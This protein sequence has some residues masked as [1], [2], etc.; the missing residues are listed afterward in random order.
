MFAADEEEAFPLRFCAFFHAN[1]GMPLRP[2][3][4]KMKP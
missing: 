3:S 2:L 4:R 1:S